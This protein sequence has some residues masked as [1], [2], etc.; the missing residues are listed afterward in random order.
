MDFWIVKNSWGTWWGE[1]GFFRMARG[2]NLCKIAN[3]ARYPVLKTDP[4]KCL[5]AITLPSS[6]RWFGDFV[7]SHGNYLKSFCIDRF[8]RTYEQ[9]LED[10]YSNGMRLYQVESDEQRRLLVDYANVNFARIF[11]FNLY[12]SGRN[13]S[14]CLNIVNRNKTYVESVEDCSVLKR[15]VCE[16]LNTSRERELLSFDV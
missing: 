8:V 9:S 10:C 1:K 14:G 11:N 16:F 13:E 4:P 12:V 7:D 15:S 5:A 3:D 6:C 2:R